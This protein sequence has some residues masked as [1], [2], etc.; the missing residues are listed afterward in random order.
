MQARLKASL[1]IGLNPYIRIVASKKA[2]IIGLAAAAAVGAGAA[3]AAAVV[4]L[5]GVKDRYIRV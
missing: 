2:R 3:V 5:L 4:S 1:I